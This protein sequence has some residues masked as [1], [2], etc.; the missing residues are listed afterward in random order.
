MRIIELQTKVELLSNK[1]NDYDHLKENMD[2]EMNMNEM[3]VSQFKEIMMDETSGK[4]EMSKQMDQIQ[5]RCAQVEHEK[6]RINDQ[7][8]MIKTKSQ[9]DLES[10]K[11]QLTA[12]KEYG[13]E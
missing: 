4:I 1:L 12:S 3:R 5:L 8:L 9:I 11:K 10:L 2:N 7:M 13:L 6:R